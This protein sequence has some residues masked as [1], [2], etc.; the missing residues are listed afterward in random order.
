MTGSLGDPSSNVEMS[1]ELGNS[2]VLLHSIECLMVVYDNTFMWC[3]W[4]FMVC[5]SRTFE[6]RD[7]S[8]LGDC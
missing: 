6:S 1:I 8:V 2:A 3:M 5:G 4:W 7:R